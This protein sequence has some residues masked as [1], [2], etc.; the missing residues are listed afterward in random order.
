MFFSNGIILVEGDAER[1]LIP[2]F[3]RNNFKKLNQ[4]YISILSVGGAHAHRL[5]GLIEKLD[6][7]CLIITDLDAV[8]EEIQLDTNGKAVEKKDGSPKYIKIK[9]IPEIGL[10]LLTNNDTLKTWIPKKE[11]IDDLIALNQNEKIENNMRICFQTPVNLKFNQEDKV[12]YPY[13]FEESIYFEN[14]EIINN[15]FT[16]KSRDRNKVKATGVLNQMIKAETSTDFNEFRLTVF[17]ALNDNKVDMAM[18]LI[19][20]LDPTELN[21][22]EYI[23]EGLVW[24]ENTIFGIDPDNSQGQDMGEKSAA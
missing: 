9:N 15:K 24:L 2:H 11:Y 3:I 17:N 16:T 12:V 6:L 1:L 23:K 20:G 13:T 14:R 21:P 10:G 19:Y 22:P 5:K 7:P 18:D 4:S 8:K